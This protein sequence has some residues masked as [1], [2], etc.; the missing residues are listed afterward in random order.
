MKTLVV[1]RII[2]TWM[3]IILT[4]LLS[5]IFANTEQFSGDTSFYRFGPHPE[6]VILGITI[7]TPEK[8]GLIVL[9]AI[10]NTIIRNLDHNII[11]P[12]ITLNVQN[13]NAQPTE[14]KDVKKHFGNRLAYILDG[15]KC[16]VGIESSIVGIE[17]DK[18]CIY[19]L[20]GLSI[21]AIE[22][23]IGPVELK[24]NQS[25]NP[26]TPGQLKN[27]YAPKK[28]LFVGDVKK[29]KQK[30]HLKKIDLIYFGQDEIKLDDYNTIY[31]LSETKDFK[32]A[33]VNLFKFLR[34]ADDSDSEI[35][36]CSELPDVD[37]GRAINDRL[38][39][40]AR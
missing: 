31:N 18:V 28:P 12:W 1:S 6:L 38:K 16:E 32:E 5:Y 29:L 24:I 3:I 19:R 4:I 7:D 23:I 40:A 34:L 17:N 15:G 35:I 27:H 30:H 11:A 9:Y 20:G 25:S 37:L 8:Y 26:K 36:I 10:I 21:E 14:L 39:R 13:I 33:A 2:T 22:K